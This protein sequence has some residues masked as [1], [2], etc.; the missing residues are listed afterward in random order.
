MEQSSTVKVDIFVGID[1]S[2][3]KFDVAIINNQGQKVSHKKFN[4]NNLGFDDFF[5]WLNGTVNSDSLF[6][7]MEY[8]GVYSR[9]LW[10]YIQD[11]GFPLWME[12]GFQIKRKSG[13]FKTK[14]DKVD[15]YRIANYALTN[16][17]NLKITPDYDE[18][19][20]ILHDLLSNRN[21]LIDC[22]KRLE[23]PLKELEKYGNQSSYDYIKDANL[24][25]IKALKISLKALDKKIDELIE[26]NTKWQNNIELASSVPGVGKLA[27]LWLLVYSKNFSNEFNAR[28]F[29]SLSGIAPFEISSGTSIKGGFHVNCYSHKQLKGILHIVAMSA[30]KYNPHMKAYFHK[31]KKEGKKGFVPINNI[32]NK[33][34][35]QVW[36]IIRS[37]KVFDLN[38]QHPKAA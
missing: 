9:K 28:Q 21:R 22:I 16:A 19:L 8:T 26:K 25:A 5:I 31:K 12:S 18:N 30:I 38:Y 3:A 10:M 6:F 29:A 33:I 32:K 24:T 20:F 15:A 7:C 36:S 4:N 14:N 27:T 37:G 17:F 11:Y 2:K 23:V 13:I 34:I 1:M 35:Q